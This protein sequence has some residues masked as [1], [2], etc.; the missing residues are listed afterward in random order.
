M[1]KLA[2]TILT[3]L[4][5]AGCTPSGTS[6]I[7]GTPR[8]RTMDVP[9]IVG[10]PTGGIDDNTP[11][12]V[13]TLH[14]VASNTRGVFEPKQGIY[15][16]AWLTSCTNKRDFEQLT[17]RGHAAFV[18]E[19]HVDD[20]IP[21]TWLLQCIAMLSTPIFIVNPPQDEDPDMTLWEQITC[22]AQ[23]IG[24]FNLPMFVAFYPPG[25]GIIPAEYSIIFRYARAMFL[26]YAP[27][28]AFVW[29]APGL[30]STHR[31][32][33]FPGHDAVDWVGVPLFA[34][35]DRDGFTIDIMERFAPFYHT[36]QAFH[37]IMVLP[38]GVSNFTR[39][40]HSHHI[41]EAAE[42]I[43][44]IYNALAS[45]PRVGLVAYG[46]AFGLIPTRRD[47]FSITIE[48]AL[49]AAYKQAITNQHFVSTLERD[50]QQSTRFARSRFDA[51]LWDGSIYVDTATLAEMAITVPRVTLEIGDRTFTDASR[52]A[53]VNAS[54]CEEHHAVILNNR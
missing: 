22:L 21:I 49:I 26:H 2:F 27:Q 20:D 53:G 12:R 46:D 17:N 37:P 10:V 48:P 19:M 13:P 30:D 23:R 38:L 18:Y 51:L 5:L 32:P 41:D 34:Q 35:R 28:V 14:T 3:L 43:A 11:I 40:G 24:A 6:P 54:F 29:V 39:E 47:D 42:E 36:F 44:R 4:F 15:L 16:A 7:T 9:T 31:N 33:F 45:F 1:K 8:S 25:H 50:S 52:L